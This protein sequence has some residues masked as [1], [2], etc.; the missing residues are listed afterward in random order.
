MKNNMIINTCEYPYSVGWAITNRCN[1][2]CVHCNMNSGDALNN[3]LQ[4]DDCIKIIDKLAENKVQRITFFGGEPLIRKDFFKIANYAYNKGIFINMTTNALMITEEMIK[5]ELYKFDMVRVSLDGPNA[6]THEFIR[7][8]KGAFDETINK[9]KMLVKNGI[10]V[11]IVTCISHRN[12]KYIKEM[13]ELLE[14]LKIKR[15]FLPLLSSAGRG[16]SISN[17]VL[18]PLEVRQFLLDIQNLTENSSFTVNLDIPYSILLKKQ[19]K[20]VTAACPAAISELVIFAN[21]DVSPCCQVPVIAGN[22]L[23]KDIFDIWNNSEI[24]KNFRD[25][26]LING[27]CGS[28]KF[29]M[30]CGGCRANAYIKY[31]DYLEG[32]DVCWK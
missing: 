22:V 30:N 11:G 17:E 7:N 12:L 28:C 32:D 14:N 10:D 21:G 9:I 1:L 27:K 13:I 18:T 20:N 16:S 25:R 24:F 26:S 31:N 2:R 3:E 8:K 5:N 15:W 6:E 4:M 29:L 23:E 19:N